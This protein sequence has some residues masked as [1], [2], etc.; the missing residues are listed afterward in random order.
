VLLALRMLG[1]GGLEERLRLPPPRAVADLVPWKARH[2]RSLAG[3]LDAELPDLRGT[4]LVLAVLD[5]HDVVRDAL[6]HALPRA[7]AEVVLLPSDA[8][9]AGVVHAA[10]AEDA[11]VIVLGTYNGAALSVGRELRAAVEQTG[12]EGVVIIG[13]KLNEDTGGD[14]PVDVADDLRALGLQ[15]AATLSDAARL[16]GRVNVP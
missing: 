14:S 8:T 1:T 11:D 10:V 15:P 12:F 4:R 9:P 2:V 6:L 7:G 16:L 5:V 3:G 13:G